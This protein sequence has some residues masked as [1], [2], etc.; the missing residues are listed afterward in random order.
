MSVWNTTK[1]P[2]HDGYSIP[3]ALNAHARL[4]TSINF[5]LGICKKKTVGNW[6]FEI[7]W[8]VMVVGIYLNAKQFSSAGTNATTGPLH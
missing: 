8:V 6:E 5:L 2:L 3:C 7:T 1:V 4:E